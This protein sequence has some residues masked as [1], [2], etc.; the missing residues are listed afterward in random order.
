MQIWKG[1]K[2]NLKHATSCCEYHGLEHGEKPLGEIELTM[3]FWR[4]LSGYH[5]SFSRRVKEQDLRDAME[6]LDAVNENKDECESV[7]GE[8]DS[9]DSEDD[10]HDQDRRSPEPRSKPK[11][12]EDDH[13]D[14]DSDSDSS[15]GKPRGIIGK[16]KALVEGHNDSN[17]GKRGL[18]SELRDYKH[19][20]KQL[21]RRH[22]GI[23]QFKA[24]RTMD[25][26][27]TKVR[28]GEGHIEN[29]VTHRERVPGIET[30]I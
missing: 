19:H 11:E 25:W 20:R 5:Q 3:Q 17:D 7:H 22:R 15:G 28:H 27:M 1:G 10:G 30:E 16:A 29:M 13:G 24:P 6:V 2:K 23:M 9:S 18:I 4:G 21:H 12:L 8:T 26:L 14:S